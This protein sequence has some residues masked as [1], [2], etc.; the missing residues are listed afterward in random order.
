DVAALHLL[1]EVD[2]FDAVA[3]RGLGHGSDLHKSV[4]SRWTK[5]AGQT[6]NYTSRKRTSLAL[7]V[8]KLRRASTS[9]PMS[10]L[11]SSSAVAASS[12]VT[13]DRIRLSGFI[14]VYHSSLAS[15]SPRPLNR[16]MPSSRGLLRP[17]SAP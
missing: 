13:C 4:H 16:W 17:A 2:R 11:N 6:P 14:V 3:G 1:L 7:R 5:I 10:T 9:S 15:I 12:R 8:M